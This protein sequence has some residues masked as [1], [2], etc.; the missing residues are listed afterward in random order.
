MYVKACKMYKMYKISSENFI[1]AQN[2]K[3]S[4]AQDLLEELLA[5]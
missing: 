3:K 1:L 4:T 2:T 5:M